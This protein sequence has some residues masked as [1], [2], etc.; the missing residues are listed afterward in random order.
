MKTFSR[1][2]RHCNSHSSCSFGDTCSC[3][4]SLF[5]PFLFFSISISLPLFV[6]LSLYFCLS[7]STPERTVGGE[8]WEGNVF[9]QCLIY[10]RQGKD[11]GPWAEY[12]EGWVPIM[13]GKLHTHKRR[14]RRRGRG[15]K[16]RRRKEKK[17]KKKNILP[18]KWQEFGWTSEEWERRWAML[19]EC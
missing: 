19:K 14:T 6:S 17:K 18:L 13:N 15:R 8:F 11:R 9:H 5:S 16:R 3:H 7:L 10:Y 2:T 12:S 4:L 1:C